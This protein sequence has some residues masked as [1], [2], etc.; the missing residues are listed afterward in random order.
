M[1]SLIGGAA[2]LREG[3]STEHLTPREARLRRLRKVA[4]CAGTLSALTVGM[5]TKRPRIGFDAIKAEVLPLRAPRS[6]IKP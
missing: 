6:V 2:A 3:K 1:T 5:T 4:N